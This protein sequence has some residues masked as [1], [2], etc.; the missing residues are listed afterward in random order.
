MAKLT[1]SEILGAVALGKRNSNTPS[2]EL[3]EVKVTA[4]KLTKGEPNYDFGG[5]MVSHSAILN[6]LPLSQR[7]NADKYLTSFRIL[8]SGSEK[9]GNGGSVGTN[10][11]VLNS[12]GVKNDTHDM[13][14]KVVQSLK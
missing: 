6:A 12:A 10:N 2:V 9:P 8:K 7:E 13:I 5:K 11:Y 4:T 14:K 3:P 1:T